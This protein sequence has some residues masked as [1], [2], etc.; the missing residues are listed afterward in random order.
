MSAQRD[1]FRMWI[2]TVV[3]AVV[4]CEKI[5]RKVVLR[6]YVTVDEEGGGGKEGLVRALKNEFKVNMKVHDC[7]YIIKI[8]SVLYI[9]I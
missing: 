2:E 4:V 6:T 1:I 5:R 8:K 7:K 9:Y 3:V